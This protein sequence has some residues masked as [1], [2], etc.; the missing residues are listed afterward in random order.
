MS[1]QPAQEDYDQSKLIWWPQEGP[2]E[3]LFACDV[4]D[5]LFGGSR[6]G[7]KTDGIIGRLGFRAHTYGKLFNAVIFR[8][9]MPSGDDL[10]DRACQIYWQTGAWIQEYNH[11]IRFREGGR[12]RFRPLE[13]VSD[14]DKYQGQNLSDVVIEEAGLYPSPDPIDRLWGAMRSGAGKV[15]ASLVLTGNPGGAGQHWVKERYIDPWPAGNRPLRVLLPNGGVHYRIFIPSKIEDNRILLE[16]DPHYINRLYMVGSPALVRA[17]LDGD[18]NAVEGA[19][20]PEWRPAK[21]VIRPFPIPKDWLRYCSMDWGSAKPFSIG[22]H[23]IANDDFKVHGRLIRRGCAVR[24]REWYGRGQKYNVGLKLTVEE[25]AKGI[26]ER[27]GWV[28]GKPN[29]EEPIKFRV[30]DP[31]IFKVDGGPSHGERFSRMGIHFGPADNRRLPEVGAMVG[32]DLLRARLKGEDGQPMLI[33]FDTC[34]DLIRTLPLV[35]HD[36]SRPEDLD[37]ESEDHALDDERYFCAARVFTP[38]G[39]TERIAKRPVDGY[40]P[41]REISWR[42]L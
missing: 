18:W 30:A 24:Y 41:K 16:N 17:W 23:A 22:W 29:P 12:M 11:T 40:R 32:W 35:Q 1:E 15:E 38:R 33:V 39:T 13:R 31:N 4:P 34:T 2:Q 19:F 3:A 37:T 6:G 36:Q 7:G 27:E 20:F 10:W 9:T 26:Q 21:H 5:I 25:V 42:E 28:N 14:A 8:Q